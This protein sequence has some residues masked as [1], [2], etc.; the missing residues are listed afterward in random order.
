MCKIVG[1]VGCLMKE[2]VGCMEARSA[3]A[4]RLPGGFAPFSTTICPRFPVCLSP[5]VLIRRLFPNLVPPV[6]RTAPRCG[7]MRI[8]GNKRISCCTLMIFLLI[9]FLRL[10]HSNITISLH[11]G[12]RHCSSDTVCVLPELTVWSCLQS[13]WLPSAA[14]LFRLP[15]P[16]Y[17]TQ[18]LR[19]SHFSVI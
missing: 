18:L 7:A 9:N 17:G 19:C 16:T 6:P 14:E 10:A 13:D 11:R 2:A 8:T 3:P 1:N 15:L 5:D 4:P 12:S